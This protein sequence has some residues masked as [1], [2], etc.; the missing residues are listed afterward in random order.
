M[1]DLGS[2]FNCYWGCC[3]GGCSVSPV[4]PAAIPAAS[5]VSSSVRLGCWGRVEGRRGGVVD[6]VGTAVVGVMPYWFAVLA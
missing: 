5:A 6:G 2:L 3:R 4:A 1:G